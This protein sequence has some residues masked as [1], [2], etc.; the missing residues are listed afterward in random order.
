MS[1][2]CSDLALPELPDALAS[3]ILCCLAP[4]CSLVALAATSA[5]WAE[6]ARHP[7]LWWHICT[8]GTAPLVL[9]TLALS[10]SSAQDLDPLKSEAWRDLAQVARHHVF[11]EWAGTLAPRNVV[12]MVEAGRVS[13]KSWIVLTTLR[14]PDHEAEEPDDHGSAVAA[15][16]AAATSSA[17][18]PFLANSQYFPFTGGFH[19]SFQVVEA[20][21][22]QAALWLHVSATPCGP[23]FMRVLLQPA[24]AVGHA[25]DVS[26]EFDAGVHPS[27][28]LDGFGDPATD[29]ALHASLR[30]GSSSILVCVDT[31]TGDLDGHPGGSGWI[32]WVPMKPSITFSDL[33][34][35][36]QPRLQ[37]SRSSTSCQQLTNV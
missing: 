6:A 34:Q 16:K 21:D 27:L 23:L 28:R 26:V 33:K 4:G 11:V 3:R 35:A 7:T 18:S 10:C 32:P 13:E 30:H 8:R 31:P 20:G 22:S 19:V 24:F 25:L 1:K 17:T 9:P 36:S 5:H 14:V 2:L 15:N 12:R 29:E 37:V